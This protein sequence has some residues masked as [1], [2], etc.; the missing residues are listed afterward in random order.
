MKISLDVKVYPN[1]NKSEIVESDVYVK[2]QPKGNKANI[3]V[4]TLFSKKYK[5]SPK[6]IK[7][8]GTTSRSK[9]IVITKED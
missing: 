8:L 6:N 4:L 5:I 2:S 9:R 7:I 3:E 1:S